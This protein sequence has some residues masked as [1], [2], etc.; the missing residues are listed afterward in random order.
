VKPTPREED[1][2]P[3]VADPAMLDPAAQ[4]GDAHQ[5]RRERF[6]LPFSACSSWQKS[7]IRCAIRP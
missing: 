7:A 6:P 1:R 4:A 5:S 3:L 2:T